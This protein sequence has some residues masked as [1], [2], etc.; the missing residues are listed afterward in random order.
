M[1]NASV[2]AEDLRTRE[3]MWP[4]Y[5]GDYSHKTYLGRLSARDLEDSDVAITAFHP[6]PNHS[7]ELM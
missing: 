4:R 1:V 6:T 7:S 3:P 5:G 2:L